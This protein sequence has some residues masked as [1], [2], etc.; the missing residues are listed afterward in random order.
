M[1]AVAYSNYG[2]PEVVQITEVDKPVPQDNE[3]LIRVHAV[4]ITAADSFMRKGE[5]FIARIGGGLSKPKG[6][7]GA[8]LAGEVEAI[9]EAVTRFK[10]GDRV[11]AA[12]GMDSGAHAEYKCLP[13][14]GAMALMPAKSSYAEAA[15]ISEGA[16]TALPFLRDKA[17]LQPGQRVLINGASGSV[18][19]A[20]VQIAKHFGAHVTGVCSGANVELVRSLGADE[21]IDYTQED[22]TQNGQSYDVIFDAIG[23]NSYGRCKN[24]LT[25]SGIYMTTVP[26]LGILLQMLWTSRMSRK[27]ATIAFAGLRSTEAKA[28]DLRLVTEWTEAGVLVPVIDRSYS[29]EEIVEAHRYVDTERKRGNVVVNLVGAAA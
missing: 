20:A 25:E 6:I 24:S 5:P 1:K 16:L 14:D 3:V 2:S 11:Y 19:T 7:P 18:G 22:F 10:V 29:F 15:A 8:E 12:T 27:K 28:A 4:T 26:S 23:K 17:K 21:V 9:G 13:E